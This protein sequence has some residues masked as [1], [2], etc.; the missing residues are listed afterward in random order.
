MPEA[1]RPSQIAFTS[2]SDWAHVGFGEG[3]ACV[4]PFDTPVERFGQLRMLDFYW[5]CYFI[6][7]IHTRHCRFPLI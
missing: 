4:A 6:P 1:N 7:D 3:F 5:I 2:S